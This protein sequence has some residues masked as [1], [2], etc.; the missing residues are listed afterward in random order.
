MFENIIGNDRIKSYLSCTAQRGTVGNSLLFAGPDGI[1]KSLFA[2]AFAK[3]LICMDDPKGFHKRRLEAGHHPD[4]RIYRPEGKVAMHSI[5]SMRQFSEEVY[6][7]PAESRWRIFII[8]DADRMLS[9]SANALLKTF[10]EP[11]KDAVIIL[12]TSSP[13]TLLPTVRSRCRSIFFH[14][15]ED[16]AIASF[17]RSRCGKTP[18]E[19]ERI[20][21]MAQGSIGQALRLAQGHEDS[22]RGKLLHILS[23]RSIRSYKELTETAALLAENIESEKKEV[24]GEVKAALMSTAGDNLTAV[25]KQEIEKEI[26][27]AVAI[28]ASQEAR[29][30]FEVIL[31]WYRDL[32]LIQAGASPGLLIHRDYMDV[33][34]K[35]LQAGALPAME[36]VQQVIAAAQLSMERSTSIHIIL[37]N[38]FL[39]LNLGL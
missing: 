11:A 13:E 18:E 12:L 5:G 39:K 26:E 15:I 32:H 2:E 35:V 4:I 23:T 9:Y 38:I 17:I 25:Q 24:E 29:V 28:Y 30:L 33:Y 31:G 36:E 27:G 21:A 16:A 3:H 1:G 37:E 8:H 19:A 20:A 34:P 7:A 14:P 6:L 10:E 22:L